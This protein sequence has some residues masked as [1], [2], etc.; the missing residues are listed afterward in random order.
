MAAELPNPDKEVGIFIYL[1]HG[2]NGANKTEKT[3]VT[4][5]VAYLRA[6]WGSAP[7]PQSLG[8]LI[9]LRTL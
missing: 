7:V 3:P 6:K 8:G 2:R 5:S 4:D 9:T 1:G